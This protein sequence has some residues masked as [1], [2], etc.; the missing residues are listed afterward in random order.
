MVA[1]D[2]HGEFSAS[3]DVV[4]PPQAKGGQQ[5]PRRTWQPADTMLRREVS[6]K[7]R[8]QATGAEVATEARGDVGADSVSSGGGVVKRSG[9]G[10]VLAPA[11]SAAPRNQWG[12][13]DTLERE[14]LSGAIRETPVCA[15]TA[16]SVCSVM[17]V[18]TG[19]VAS[20]ME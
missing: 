11:V 3:G 15:S 18:S 7:L 13:A 1:S 19:S 10:A 9:A 6:D 14:Q 20:N 8:G 12:V 17:S 2:E 4:A 5:P 16:G